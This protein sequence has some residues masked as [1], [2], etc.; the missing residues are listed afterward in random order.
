[1]T[2]PINLVLCDIDGCLNAGLHDPL[3]LAAIARI[4]WQIR[5]FADHGI[6]FGLCTGR[7]VPFA[8]AMAQVLGTTAPLVCENGAV[9]F[10]PARGRATML[11]SPSDIEALRDLGARIVQSPRWEVTLE[12]GKSACVSLNG[13]RITGARPDQ[14]R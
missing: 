6:L 13:A 10:D 7:P 1:M 14:D 4:A 9:V 5:A 12:P 8:Q 2:P 11:P 3:D